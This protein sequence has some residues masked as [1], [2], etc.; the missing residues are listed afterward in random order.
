MADPTPVVE[1][2]ADA[3]ERYEMETLHVDQSYMDEARA[4][5]TAA[6][7]DPEDPDSLARILFALQM[8][9]TDTTMPAE[10]AFRL[11]FDMAEEVRA[12]WRAI[13]NGLRIMLVG[14]PS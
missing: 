2:A 13:A 5:L 8:C 9:A 7:T 1:R 14:R 10:D 6:L 12:H 11:W 3:I 4:A